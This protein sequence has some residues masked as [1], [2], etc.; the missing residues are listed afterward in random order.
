MNVDLEE[1]TILLEK[2]RLS[3]LNMENLSKELSV[4]DQMI[5]LSLIHHLQKTTPKDDLLQEQVFIE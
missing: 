2:P 4:W 5:V 3:D 1:D